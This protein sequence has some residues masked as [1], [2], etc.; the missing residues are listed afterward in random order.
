MANISHA[1]SS[2]SGVYACAVE[3]GSVEDVSRIVRYPTSK[4]QLSLTRA[5]IAT[6]PRIKPNTFS[7]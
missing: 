2:S 4:C 5:F 3:S 1:A 7:Q 6:Y